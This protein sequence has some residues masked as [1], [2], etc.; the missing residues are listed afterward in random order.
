MHLAAAALWTATAYLLVLGRGSS[1]SSEE[2]PPSSTQSLVKG[3]SVHGAIVMTDYMGEL[4][5]SFLALNGTADGATNPNFKAFQV[6]AARGAHARAVI[7]ELPFPVV[8]WPP[9]Y[10]KNCPPLVATAAAHSAR[11]KHTHT[12]RGLVLAHYQVWLEFVFFDHDVLLERAKAAAGKN[13]HTTYSSTDFSSVSGSFASVNNSLLFKNNV[14]FLDDDILIVLEDDVDIAVHNHTVIIQE[15]LN[16]MDV[17]LLFLGWCDGR[18]ARPVP[19]C[20]HAYAVTRRAARKLIQHLEPCGKALDEQFVVMGKNK[21]IT[22]RT[23][24]RWRFE[25]FIKEGWTHGKTKGIFQQLKALGSL[26]GH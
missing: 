11:H 4:T 6:G 26:N 10:T 14:P 20:A 24:H 17:D 13:N 18:L 8:E 15:E 23:A 9:I 16:S 12:E 19:L 5:R 21:W 1:S 25:K 3:R 2:T 7:A 22:F